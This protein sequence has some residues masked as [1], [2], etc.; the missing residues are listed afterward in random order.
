MVLRVTVTATMAD[1]IPPDLHL[2]R[3]YVSP[4]KT[5]G[6]ADFENPQLPSPNACHASDQFVW[7]AARASGAAP[8]F[9][10][11]EGNFV[12]GGICSNNPSLELLTEIVEYNVAQRAVGRDDEVVTPTVMVSLGTGVL[13]LKKVMLCVTFSS[14]G[15]F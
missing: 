8:S 9:F 6:I 13:P 10:R 12:D 15:R 4:Q 5:L 14:L 2:F 7:K 11:P 3:S 1:R